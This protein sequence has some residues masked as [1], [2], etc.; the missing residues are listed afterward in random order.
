MAYLFEVLLAVWDKALSDAR[1]CGRCSADQVFNFAE[2]PPK[3][4]RRR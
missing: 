4:L 2:K 1:Q 3:I